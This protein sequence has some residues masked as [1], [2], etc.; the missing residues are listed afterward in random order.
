MKKV[1]KISCG[2]I[3]SENI[4]ISSLSLRILWMTGRK[5]IQIWFLK[6]TLTL[7]FCLTVST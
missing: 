3:F 7:N 4:E 1:L 5:K 6:G 2:H